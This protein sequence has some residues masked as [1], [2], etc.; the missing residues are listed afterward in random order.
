M[1]APLTWP[2]YGHDPREDVAWFF[3][4]SDAASFAMR[5]TDFGAEQRNLYVGQPKHGLRQSW[6]VHRDI[7]PESGNERVAA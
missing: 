6:T 4:W 2:V 5:P 1:N 3:E 7:D